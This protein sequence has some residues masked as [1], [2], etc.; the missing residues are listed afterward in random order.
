M[1][2]ADICSYKMKRSYYI[3]AFNF[4]LFQ[5]VFILQLHGYNFGFPVK[6]IYKKF[7]FARSFKM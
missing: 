1:L 2:T 5:A 6:V 4:H 3:D 7:Y